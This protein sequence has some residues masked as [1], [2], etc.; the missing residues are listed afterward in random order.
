MFR[1]YESGY[2]RLREKFGRFAGYLQLI[3]PFTLLAPLMAGIIGVLTP[4]KGVT[5]DHLVT[6]VYAGITLALTQGCGQ[7]LNQYADSDLDKVVKPYRP[8]PSGLVSREEALG[9]SWL[10]AIVSIGRSFVLGN[11][12]ALVVLTLLFFA[13]FY[14]IAPF[15]PRKVNPWI[16]VWWMAFSRGFLP[17]LA[18]YSVYGVLGN[19]FAYA[20]LGFLWVY[21][22]QSTKDIEDVEGDYE[23]G[24]KT[25]PTEYGV[26]MVYK[27]AIVCLVLYT[28]FALGYKPYMVLLTPVGVLAI[29]LGRRKS[30]LTEN[31]YGWTLFYMGLAMFYL[32]GFAGSRDFFSRLLLA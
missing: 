1:F 7:T 18:V 9:V 4:V 21:G 10:L 6:G 27:V 15:S 31:N 26:D 8:I 12:F 13:V 32:L 11:F 24:I 19:A 20:I 5:W 22:L 23:Y 16:N 2:P 28:V 29:V 14:S 3:R 25:I 17:V 30:G